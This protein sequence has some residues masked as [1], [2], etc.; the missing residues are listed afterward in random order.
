[1]SLREGLANLA[2]DTRSLAGGRAHRRTGARQ[3]TNDSLIVALHAVATELQRTPGVAA[4]RARRSVRPTLPDAGTIVKRFGTWSNA[5]RAAGLEP[6]AKALSPHFGARAI[7]DQEIVTAL[8]RAASI[9]G[10]A[11]TI[12]Q[13]TAHVG[14][15]STGTISNRF[16]SWNLAL[17]AA[18]P[19]SVG[20]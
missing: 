17:E 18:F 12:E 9:V 11:P 6:N 7:T 19:T 16:G 15:P 4:Y 5:V 2:R 10:H 14:S 3:Y 8:W 1:M 13:Y 20:H